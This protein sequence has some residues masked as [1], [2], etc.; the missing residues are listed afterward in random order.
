MKPLRLTEDVRK[1]LHEGLE[2]LLLRPMPE[3]AC[4]VAF[5]VGVV[6][7][8]GVDENPLVIVVV[9]GER[10]IA[11]VHKALDGAHK[12]GGAFEVNP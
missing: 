12:H 5:R 10:A 1:Q 3:G 4:E 11:V 8:D 7:D 6:A 9:L 2:A